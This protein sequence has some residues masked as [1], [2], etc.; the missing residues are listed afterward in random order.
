MTRLF[1]TDKSHRVKKSG[2]E[3][4]HFSRIPI[5]QRFKKKQKILFHKIELF[6]F[7]ELS[8]L[9]SGTCEDTFELCFR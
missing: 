4:F 6:K 1:F 8:Y 9:N 3:N 2:F 7:V 5:F